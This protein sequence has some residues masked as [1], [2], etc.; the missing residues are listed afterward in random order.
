MKIYFCQELN[1]GKLSGGIFFFE[2]IFDWGNNN[3]IKC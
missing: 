1:I 2:K 3:I